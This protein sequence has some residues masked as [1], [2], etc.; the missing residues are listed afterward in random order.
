MKIRRYYK[1]GVK[2]K[3]TICDEY[4]K[5]LIK[6]KG[7]EEA[8]RIDN[9]SY[10]LLLTSKEE[11]NDWFNDCLNRVITNPRF[12]LDNLD[13]LMTFKVRIQDIFPK[14]KPF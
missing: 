12:Y 10:E 13:S 2:Y 11:M 6:E 8:N 4:L 3:Y 1:K 5:T 14:R 7:V 9:A